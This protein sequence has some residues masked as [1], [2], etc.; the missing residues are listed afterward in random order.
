MPPGGVRLLSWNCKMMNTTDLRDWE[1][2]R[3]IEDKTAR[4]AALAAAEASDLIC[5]QE[6]PGPQLRGS[7]AS[8][9]ARGV[10]TL[11]LALTP[12]LTHPNL[13]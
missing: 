10:V 1:W 2:A 8:G 5:I 12:T 4:L 9:K 6:C 13:P 11:N 7:R 3:A